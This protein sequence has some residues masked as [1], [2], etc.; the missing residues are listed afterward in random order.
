MNYRRNG[1][2]LVEVLVALAI[3]GLSL[4]AVAASMSQMIDGAHTMRERTYASWIAQNKITELRLG[5]QLPELGAT[6]GALEYANTDWAWRAVIVET[7]VEE[8]YRIDVTVS[9][10]HSEDAIRTVTGFVGTPG[11]AGGANQIWLNMP[12]NF[13][14]A[15]QPDDGPE[16]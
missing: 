1:F 6:S 14:Q 8:L 10:A 4:S 15:N 3:V 13:G 16:Q 12:Q 5:F 9:L 11:I 2:T 7:G